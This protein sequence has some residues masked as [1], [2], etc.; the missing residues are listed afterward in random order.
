MLANRLNNISAD[1]IF[2]VWGQSVLGWLRTKRSC[3]VVFT[4][5][6]KCR[7]LIYLDKHC[8]AV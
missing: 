7:G 8:C 2:C 5:Q 6:R 4:M 1:V 3:D